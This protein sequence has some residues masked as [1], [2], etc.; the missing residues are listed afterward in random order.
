MAD[1]SYL[2]QPHLHVQ[3]PYRP[4]VLTYPGNLQ[5]AL[6]QA[7]ENSE[8]TLFGIGQGIPSTFLTKVFAATKPDFI[9]I[10]VEHGMYDRLTLHDCIH[11]A[12][13]HSEGKTMVIVRVPKHDEVSLTTALDAGAAGIMIPCCESAQ[14]VEHFM[15]EIYYPP[16]GR[17]S[18]S[19]WVFTPGISDASLYEDD[20]F[21]MQSSNR[22]VA[23]IAQ[24]ESVEGVKNIDEIAAV[25]GVSAMMFGP[26]DFSADA[27]I[28]M[29]L[30]FAQPHPTLVDALEKFA[31]AGQK[32]GIPLLGYAADA[33]MIPAM[34]D[35]GYR[36]ILLMF[37]VWGVSHLLHGKVQEA[38]EVVQK[39]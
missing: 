13:H 2:N 3:A 12:N 39:K 28:P 8:K 9:W 20:G 19:P 15:N 30:N 23:V 26:G 7:Q 10:D 37:D 6:R 21:N 18:F 22:H 33:K 16:V 25:K 32:A 1:R 4:A 34:V 17:R 11:A 5:E 29:S 36:M 38:K 27:R 31:K 24:I 14:E 35:Q